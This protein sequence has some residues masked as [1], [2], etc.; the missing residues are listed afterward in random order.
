MELEHGKE[1]ALRGGQSIAKVTK[2]VVRGSG[3]V[4]RVRIKARSSG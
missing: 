4:G 3:G 1:S 2:V